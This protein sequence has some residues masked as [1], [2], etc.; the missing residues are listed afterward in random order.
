MWVFCNE[1]TCFD[2]LYHRSY[3]LAE[4]VRHLPDLLAAKKQILT[5]FAQQNIDIFVGIDA[6][7][8]NLRLGKVLKNEGIFCVQYVSPSVWAWRENR[9]HTIKSATDLVLCLFDF[10]LPVYQKHRHPA[11]C[12]G[13]PLIK[14]LRPANFDKAPN[15]LCLMAGSRLGEIEAILPILL[16]SFKKL[17]KQ[18]QNLRAI[19]PLAKDEH[20]PLVQSLIDKNAPH[21]SPFLT[22]FSPQDWHASDAYHSDYNA[23]QYAM[24]ISNLTILASGTATLEALM[25]KAPMVVVYKVNPI[26]YAIAKRL[27]KTP[28]VALP[29]ILHHHRYGTPLV[30]ELL[31]D[32]ANGDDISQAVL[33]LL[34][35]PCDKISQFADELHDNQNQNPASIV[36]IHYQQTLKIAS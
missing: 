8:F 35:H 16:D 7:D 17:F 15:T 27:I 36:L 11:V 3:I 32:N 18:N 1:K 14:Q 10:E 31:Q 30:P 9:I 5:A 23:S 26:T 28:F 6:P 12:V 33:Q 25:L 34:N 19:L 4:V 29:N 24:Q 20:K 22:V 13:H 2:F 21:L